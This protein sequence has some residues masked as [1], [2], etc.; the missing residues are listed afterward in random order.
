[1]ATT[2]AKV[3]ASSVKSPTTTPEQQVANLG[4][5]PP[6][7]SEQQIDK[8]NSPEGKTVPNLTRGT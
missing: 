4:G 6:T 3:P 8:E 2:P 1:M 7:K 5:M